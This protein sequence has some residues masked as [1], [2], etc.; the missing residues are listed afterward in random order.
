M[1]IDRLV[2][3]LLD[4]DAMKGCFKKELAKKLDVPV[5]NIT[6]VWLENTMVDG[7]INQTIRASLIDC[8]ISKDK[9]LKLDFKSIYENVLIF[10]VGDILL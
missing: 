3:S 7:V 4:S 2:I 6:D 5:E 8:E 9:L 10:E 1:D